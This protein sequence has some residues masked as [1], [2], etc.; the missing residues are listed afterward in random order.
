[1]WVGSYTPYAPYDVLHTV[2]YRKH[3][4]MQITYDYYMQITFRLHQITHRLVHITMT[5]DLQTSCVQVHTHYVHH[6]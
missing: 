2:A 6:I 1:M 4:Y 3:V 5:Y